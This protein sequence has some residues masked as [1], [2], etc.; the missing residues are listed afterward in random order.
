M[1][2]L[3]VRHLN[4]VPSIIVTFFGLAYIWVEAPMQAKWIQLDL[5]LIMA[6]I[7]H[8]FYVKF[9]TLFIVLQSYLVYVFVII[10]PGLVDVRLCVVVVGL[11]DVVVTGEVT[12]MVVHATVAL[13]S[14]S[15]SARIFKGNS[16]KG[17]PLIFSI[18]PKF[19]GKDSQRLN[20][21]DLY[22]PP[23]W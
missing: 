12:S 19:L 13:S 17:M 23:S 20:C 3:L 1:I 2:W 9:F 22:K 5:P 18:V 6:G 14:W 21:G 4:S 7:L 10:L 8:A 15:I 11:V 16:R